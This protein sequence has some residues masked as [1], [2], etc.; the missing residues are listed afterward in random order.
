MGIVTVEC[1]GA[2]SPPSPLGAEPTNLISR[3]AVVEGD[4]TA[5]TIAIA[6][7][8]AYFSR[9]STDVSNVE[10]IKRCHHKSSQDEQCDPALI[11][12][13]TYRYVFR[14]SDTASKP[15]AGTALEMLSVMDEMKATQQSQDRARTDAP[16]SPTPSTRSSRAVRQPK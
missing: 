16:K 7:S 2:I 6:E 4:R 3:L 13:V 11:T 12:E 15:G 1:R 9:V 5:A 10:S 14:V 8:K